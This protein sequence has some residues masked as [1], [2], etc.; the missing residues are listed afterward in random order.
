MRRSGFRT[1]AL[2]TRWTAGRSE[3]KAGGHP[4]PSFL[5]KLL[6]YY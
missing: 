6:N 2:V 5:G 4:G 3:C 1:M